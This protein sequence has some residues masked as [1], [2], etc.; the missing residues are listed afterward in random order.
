MHTR[1]SPPAILIYDFVLTFSMEVERYWKGKSSFRG[2]SLLFFINRYL[3]V[4]L[5]FP[6]VYEY[7]WPMPESVSSWSFSVDV[8]IDF[9]CLTSRV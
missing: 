1:R 8:L 4:V 2:A 6:V 3:S 9:E 7:F 5:S